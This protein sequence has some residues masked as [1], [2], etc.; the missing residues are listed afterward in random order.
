MASALGARLLEGDGADI[1][2]GGEGLIRL[3]RIDLSGLD[4][5]VRGVRIS[6][7]CDV[8]S[9]LVGPKGSARM[10]GPQKGATPKQVVML[11]RALGHLAA[12]IDRDLA[13]DVRSMPGGGAAGGL[14]AGLVAF[15]GARL[16]SGTSLVLESV[17]FAERLANADLVVT[18]EGAVDAS[19][20]TGKVVGA[21][22]DATR[23]ARLPILV[24]CGRAD[25][26]PPGVPVATLLERFGADRSLGDAR[27]A[28]EDLAAEVAARAETLAF[29][30]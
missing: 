18:G 28:L 17:G 21:V 20:F 23:S 1:P 12:V 24:L 22:V 19:S 29:A 2:P 6:A 8:D 25:A 26:R 13:V 30:P 14:G 15:L 7:A 11:E 16:R 5:A 27:L 3:A 4:P 9:P 10:F